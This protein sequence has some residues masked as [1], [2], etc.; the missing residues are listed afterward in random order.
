MMDTSRATTDVPD[1][2]LF[3]L[4]EIVVGNIPF[5]LRHY[6]FEEEE[7]RKEGAEAAGAVHAVGHRRL[8]PLNE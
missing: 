6:R 3:E 7:E 1:E 2:I 4:E 5:S 8:S